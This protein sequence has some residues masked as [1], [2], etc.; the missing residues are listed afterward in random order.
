[1]RAAVLVP[2][3]SFGE[4]KRR[5]AGVLDPTSRAELSRWMAARVIAAASP[6]P[7]YVVCDHEDV[8]QWATSLGA[9]VLW[10]PGHGLNAAVADGVST[11]AGEGVSVV[12][13][14][15]SDLPLVTRLARFADPHRVV[16][17]PDCRDDGT[18]VIA[19]PTDVPFEFGYGA[20]SF[21]RH[22]A[23]CRRLGVGH[24]V[25]RDPYAGRD[26][27]TPDDLADQLV[28]EVLPWGPTSQDN[29]LPRRR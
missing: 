1:V 9:S 27:D 18:N 13:V 28:Q 3:K 17:I 26:V 23:T 8:A 20:G 6:L 14:S 16:L 11:L 19:V 21:H 15:H 29:L 25:V 12:I 2:V 7:A 4:A 22:L 5:L 10:R 24:R